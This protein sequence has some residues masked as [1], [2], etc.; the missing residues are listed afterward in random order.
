MC[1][2]TVYETKNGNEKLVLEHVSGL[3]VE[4]GTVTATDIMG[5]KAVVVG[6]IKSIDMERSRVL[7]E[8]PAY[9]RDQ[10]D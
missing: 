5:A 4:E 9:R 6:V 3:S 10:M 7:I 1:L 2:L 8:A